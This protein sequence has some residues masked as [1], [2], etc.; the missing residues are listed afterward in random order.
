MQKIF[1]ILLVLSASLVACNQGASQTD[2]EEAAATDS[3]RTPVTVANVE[4]TTINDSISLNATSVYLQSSFVKSSAIGYVKSVT[5]KPGDYVTQGKVLFTVETKESQVIGNSISSLDS[6]FKFS[7]IN[8][9]KSPVQ[10]FVTQLDHQPGDYVQDGDQLA[11]ISDMSSFAFLLNLPYELRP[12]VLNKKYVDLFLPDG[13]H[14]QGTIASVMP[15]VDSSSQ[16]Q[17]VVIKVNSKTP[18]PQNLIA[19]VYV[20]KTMKSN[21]QTIAKS[22]V[23]SDEAQTSFWIMKLIDSTTAVKVN[24]KKGIE[25]NNQVEIL[26]PRFSKT[27]QILVTGNYGMAD[28]AKVILEKP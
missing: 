3:V 14:L 4:T 17:P 13:T 28:T 15:T 22:A 18:I 12:F 27:D 8:T 6:S 26:E 5:V 10:G 16:T 2:K 9:M 25:Y 7:G 24:I 1:L 21:A 23:L 19:K 11:V 20:I